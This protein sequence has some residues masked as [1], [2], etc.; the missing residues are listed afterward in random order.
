MKVLSWNVNG[1]ELKIKEILLKKI[2]LSLHLDIILL[3][4]TKT[5]V[6]NLSWFRSIRGYILA[7]W[8][9]VQANGSKDGL[10]SGWNEFVWCMS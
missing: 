8:D 4:E 1:L 3:L 9:F 5:S 6:I 2:I 7:G 10:L